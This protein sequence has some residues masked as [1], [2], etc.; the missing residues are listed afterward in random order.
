MELIHGG[1][2]AG[3][4]ARHGQM[5]LDF[6]A[7]VSPLG[8]PDGVRRAIEKAAAKT[9][10][11][12]NPLCRELCA[13]IAE[14]EGLPPE[15]ILCGNGAADLIYRAVLARRPHR[16]LL[17][18]PTFAEYGAAL[19]LAGCQTAY[20]KLRGETGFI[21]DSGILEAIQPGVD[22]VFLCQP[23]NPTGLTIPRPL[24]IR[25]LKQCRSVGALLVL[26]ECFCDFLD[27]PAACSLTGELQSTKNLLILKSFTKLYAMAGVRLGYCLSADPALLEAM[28]SAGP[29]WSVSSLAQAA[30]LAALDEGNYVQQ[31][32]ALIRAERPW[33]AAELKDLGLRVVPGEANYLLF[34]CGTPLAVP[35]AE[36]GILLRECGNY[37]GLDETWYRSAV[38]THEENQ[39]LIQAL[40]EVLTYG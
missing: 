35:L 34:R 18:A 24:L 6:S 32:Q 17:T 8:I 9:D 21:F 40:R 4:A 22:M 30:G 19:R 7:N 25:I 39:H 20:Y 16:A 2:W 10:R 28:A 27:E 26:D 33:L 15:R 38:R 11:Y 23:N 31:V 5:P 13:G 37:R 1:D 12:P 14:K 3:F 36:K 29:P